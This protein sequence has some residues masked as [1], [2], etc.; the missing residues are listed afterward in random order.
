MMMYSLTLHLHYSN[1]LL[2]IDRVKNRAYRLKILLCSQWPEDANI[3][4]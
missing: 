1:E 3:H 4:T 2:I